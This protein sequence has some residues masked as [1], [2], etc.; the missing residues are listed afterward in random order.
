MVLHFARPSTHNRACVGHGPGL[1]G[2]SIRLAFL[3]AMRSLLLA[4]LIGSSRIAH[5]IGV[6]AHPKEALVISNE[7]EVQHDASVSGSDSVR[8]LSANLLKHRLRTRHGHALKVVQATA[9][10]SAAMTIDNTIRGHSL[11]I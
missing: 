8:A 6:P 2:A 10:T 5:V 11:M 4:L 9:T 3:P 7:D 1:R